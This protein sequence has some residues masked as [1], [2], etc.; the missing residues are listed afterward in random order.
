MTTLAARRDA[1]GAAV[2]LFGLVAQAA[3]PAFHVQLARYLGAGGYGLYTWSQAVVDVLSVA[4]LF[5]CDQAVMRAV[6]LDRASAARAVGSALRVV[7]LS[8]LA[9]FAV[10]YA[11]APLIAAAQHKPELVAPLRC[12]AI[13]PL[14]YHVST[15]LLVATQAAGIMRYMFWA[16]SVAQPIVLLVV[17]GIALRAGAGPAGA[18][19]AVAIGMG[20]TAIASAAFY[21]RAFALG[22]AV[23]AALS[24]ALDREVLRV[25]FPL[26][27]A[28]MLWAVAARVDS[29]FLGHYASAEDLGAYAACVLYATSITQLRGAFEPT[30]SALVAPAIARGDARGLGGAIQRQTRWL[31]L[32]ALPLAALFVGF[33]DPLLR[34]FGHAFTEGRAALAALA[35]GHVAN[36]LALASFT[37]PLSGHARATTMVAAIVVVV[38]SVACVVLVPRWGVLGAAIAMSAGLVMAQVAQNVIAAKLLGVVGVPFDVVAI[39]AC[40]AVAVAIG[41][42]AFGALSLDLAPRFF[43][44]V[45]LAAGIY[46]PLAW[47]VAL[48]GEDRALVRGALRRAR[49]MW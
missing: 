38:Q 26:A 49:E 10:V 3:L 15:V 41:R 16:R 30:T 43:A 11:A 13:V 6:S 20:A 9:M 28:G 34:V 17:T 42:V 27:L 46:A 8:G 31:S 45:A 25:A 7:V 44:S 47:T 24:G 21:A 29:F 33:G 22:P 48:N 36:A 19:C 32:L 40:A 14:L 37:I 5:G 18:A 23:R 35:I 4:T 1:R 39:A 2:N 12:L